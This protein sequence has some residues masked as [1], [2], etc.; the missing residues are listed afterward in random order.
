MSRFDL[1]YLPAPHRPSALGWVLAIAGALLL[2]DVSRHLV[3]A[4]DKLAMLE[5]TRQ[6]H[7]VELSAPLAGATPSGTRESLQP[8]RVGTA[9]GV[10]VTPDRLARAEAIARRL[11]VPWESLFQAI[12]A[13]PSRGVRLL[14]IL[15]DPGNRAL[16]VSGEAKDYLAMLNYVNALAA[17]GALSEVHLVRHEMRAQDPRFTVS[18]ELQASWASPA[19]PAERAR[20][21]T[22]KV[23][24]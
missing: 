8:T 24:P 17:P 14:A 4:Q 13:I 12:E 5:R 6:L 19:A 20:D 21:P 2:F 9:P 10:A 18:F 23:R 1:N 3:S 11:V 15:P 7:R 22:A 16:T